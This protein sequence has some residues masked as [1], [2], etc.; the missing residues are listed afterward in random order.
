[1][2]IAYISARGLLVDEMLD[3]GSDDHGKCAECEANRDLF[4]RC[5]IDADFPQERVEDLIEDRYEDKQCDGIQVV[6]TTG[7]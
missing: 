2:A 7:R 5:E 4:D 1:M 6:D 3:N